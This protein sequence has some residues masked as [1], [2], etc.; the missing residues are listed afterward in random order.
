MSKP[1]ESSFE[2]S[3]IKEIKERFPGAIVSKLKDRQGIPDRLILYGKKW[4]ALELKR[5]KN[6]VHQPNQDWY[7]NHMNS[8]SFSR[9][10]Y[11]ENKDEVFRELISF[12]EDNERKE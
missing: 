6:A 4:A 1:L 11:P 12:F 8:M 7:V 10:V 3:L 5:D 9:F 2:R